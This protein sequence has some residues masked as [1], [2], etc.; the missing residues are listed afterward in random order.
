MLVEFEHEAVADI[1]VAARKHL[2]LRHGVFAQ[3]LRAV[4]HEAIGKRRIDDFAQILRQRA[5]EIRPRND[6]LFADAD[7]K[8]CVDAE[9]GI[10]QVEMLNDDALAAPHSQP[11]GICQF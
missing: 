1:A 11:D 2:L 10:D 7:E 4:R 3:I 8:I 9:K 6:D 5:E